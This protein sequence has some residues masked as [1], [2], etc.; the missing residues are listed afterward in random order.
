MDV[1]L[2]LDRREICC[3]RCACRYLYWEE[4]CERAEIG[5]DGGVF[6]SLGLVDGF[7]GIAWVLIEN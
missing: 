3:Q 5:F 6:G 4:E 2:A 7:D 1:L